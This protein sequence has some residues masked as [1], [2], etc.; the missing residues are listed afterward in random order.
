MNRAAL[1]ALVLM[2]AVAC[3]KREPAGLQGYVEGEFVR[4]AAPFAGTLVRLE[5]ARGRTVQAGTPLFFLESESEEAARR[6]AAE[7]A[8]KAQV[9]VQD[10]Q[11]GKRPTEIASTQ[12]QL[13]QAEA[14]ADFSEKELVRTQDLVAKGFVSHSKLDEARAARDRDRNRVAEMRADLATARLGFRE[15]EVRAAQ[16]EA[17]AAREALAQA[18]WRLRQKSVAAPVEGSVVDTLFVLG[19]W[20]PAGAPVVS[21]LPPAN[22]KVRFF[23]EES[24]L[25]SL[26]IGQEIAIAC[27]GCGAAVRAPITFIAPQAEYTPPVIYSKDSRAKL[28]FL[29]EARPA[30]QDAVRLHP[31][32]PVDVTLP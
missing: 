7:R 18:D 13:A 5:T 30:S 24:R 17:A 4:V 27:D 29:V 21:L 32:Q 16:A 31:G 3:G 25:G 11:S 1:L 20:V 15:G 19:E 23:V 8:R 6:E 10:L 14:A 9:Q 28:V 12:A 26:H 2:A 22:V